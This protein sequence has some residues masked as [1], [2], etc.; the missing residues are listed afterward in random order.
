MR[1][2]VL[3]ALLLLTFAA[4]AQGQDDHA[5]DRAA[6]EAFYNALGGDNWVDNTGWKDP[7]VP[8]G[9]WFGITTEVVGGSARVT[10]VQLQLNN[11]TGRVPQRIG[12]LTEV[13]RLWLPDNEID[14][15]P[16][17]IARLTKMHWFEVSNNNLR[18]APAEIAGMT[19]IRRLGLGGNE[20]GSFPR[21]LGDMTFVQHLSLANNG[22]DGPLPADRKSVV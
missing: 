10:D 12:D 13:E 7:D 3:T 22:V 17:E 21:W 8:M 19:A 2:I 4:A 18:D 6:L 11:L 16:P 20:L 9:E 5:G 15:V 1:R 14:G